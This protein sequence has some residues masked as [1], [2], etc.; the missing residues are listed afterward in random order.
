MANKLYIVGIGPGDRDYI[1]PAANKLIEESDVLIGGRRNLDLFLHLE[2]EEVIIKNKLADI[3][4]YILENAGKK[5]MVVLASGDP[6]VFSI[7]EYLKSKLVDMEM[8]VYPGI[9]S[10]QYLCAR[11][12]KSWE[13]AFI[14]S[15]HGRELQ[16][17]SDVVR[18]HGKVIIFTGGG[19]SPAS[20]CRELMC[21]GLGDVTVTVGEKLSYPEERII[22]GSPEK[23]G[24]LEFD[25][26][27]IMLLEN[28]FPDLTSHRSHDFSPC[29][30]WKFAVPGIPDE[31]FVRGEVPMTKE[32]IRTVTLS[33]LRLREDSV[34]YDIGAGT[35]SVSIECG[36]TAKRGK[37]YAVEKEQDALELIRANVMKFEP[38]NVTIVDGTA[39][40]ILAGL[41][42]PDRIFIGGTDGRLDSILDWA[43]KMDHSIRIVV[44]AVALETACE[45]LAGLNSRGFRN[46]DI[47][48]V[49]VSK[50]RL[51]GKKHLM[52]A[53]N[54][55]YIINA[56]K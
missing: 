33:K 21:N 6:G 16:N 39:P 34:V 7:S 29:Q 28:P 12:H 47:T 1:Y 43:A 25:S 19:S 48:S 18:K 49:S 22:A 23:I 50:G 35:G 32:E 36:L 55:V 14:A 11:L 17:L 26:L 44:N 13:D 37:V 46:V 51:A 27:S 53:L 45:A 2:K 41:P 8:V 38:G 3:E 42:K 15:L 30:P 5:K 9:S 54:P 4:R 10:F 31:L 40:D 24:R 20:V 56:E 52:Q